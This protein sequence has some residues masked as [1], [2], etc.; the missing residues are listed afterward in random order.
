[1][2]YSIV[3]AYDVNTRLIG[4]HGKLPWKHVREDMRRFASLTK[5]TNKDKKNI[6]VMGRETWESLPSSERPLPGRLNVVLSKTEGTA[7]GIRKSDESRIQTRVKGGDEKEADF[8][9]DSFVSLELWHEKNKESYGETFVVGGAQLYDYCLNKKRFTCKSI[10]ITELF[11]F[12]TGLLGTQDREAEDERNTRIKGAS[13]FATDIDFEKDPCFYLTELSEIQSCSNYE[14]LSYRFRKYRVQ[15]PEMQYLELLGT[16]IFNDL[17]ENRTGIPAYS[18]NGA[19]LTFDFDWGFP[20]LTTKKVFWK[21]VVEELLWFLRGSTDV[22]ELQ[23]KGVHIWDGN[24][25]REYLDSVGLTDLQEW[26][27]GKG[28]GYQWRNFGG[29]DQ[30]KEIERQLRE[31]PNSRRILLTAWN[32]PELKEMSLQPC[33]V[34]YQFYL[35]KKRL[36]CHMFL[37]S[38]DVFLGLPF[39]IASTAL[40]TAMLAVVTGLEAGGIQI[41][42]TDAHVYKTHLEAA[43]KQLLRRP[44]V[45]PWI[46]FKKVPESIL[47]FTAEDFEV[48]GYAPMESIEAEM[49]V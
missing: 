32:P 6:V 39:N 2:I 49:V 46:T 17:K 9:F 15:Y 7:D 22:T 33:H 47:D 35:H 21:G 20:L 38:S 10:Y 42:I 36:W 29:T 30:I 45:S 4:Y 14:G 16:C 19:H 26:S 31:E 28:Y 44:G 37:R 3:V 1:M 40:L 8:W 23:E 12:D 41:S 48:V 27:I 24:S 13:Y 5:G 18:K 25:S 34:I 11:G 43:R